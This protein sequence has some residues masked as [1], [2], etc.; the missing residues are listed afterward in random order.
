MVSDAGEL[1]DAC[2]MTR[3]LNETKQT[4]AVLSHATIG[5][6]DPWQVLLTRP[7]LEPSL[8]RSCESVSLRDFLH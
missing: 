3:V 1:E 6:H 7:R 8:Y 2:Y 5:I 4:W